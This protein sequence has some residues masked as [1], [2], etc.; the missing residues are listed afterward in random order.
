MPDKN[1]TALVLAAGKGT[2][3]HSAKAKVLQTILNE[4]MLFY[5]YEAL[6]PIMKEN[7]L[8]VVGHGVDEVKKE[9]PDMANRFVM[10]KEQLGT[11]HALQEA[12]AE[13]EKTNSTHCLVIN[14]DTPLVTVEALDRLV[15]AQGC[16]DLAFM[17]ITPRDTAAFGRVVRDPE[18]R[19]KAIVEAKDYDFSVH[20]PVTGEVNAGI[21]LLKIE[22]IGP[23]LG[24]LENENNSGEYYITDLVELAVNQGLSVDGVQAGNDI[25]LMGINSP[26]ELLTAENTLK[27][28]IVDE[29]I[30][31]GV[32]IHNPDTVTIGPKVTV[33][34]GA[35]IFG[36]CEI[37]G[38]SFVAAGARMGSYNFIKDSTFAAG[39]VVREFNHIEGAQVGEG[40]S[41]GPYSRLRPDAVLAKNSRIGNFV[42]MK[43][44]TLGEGAKASHLTYL[45][46]A[47]V[48]AGA[49]IGAGTIT[50]NYDGRNKFVTKIGEGAFI[51]SNTALVAPVSVGKHALIGAGSTI[52]K[53]VPD[54]QTGIARG[55]QTNLKRTLKK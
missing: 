14:G 21:Y 38:K 54:N 41:V 51:G 1:I 15:A 43:K 48:G 23:L 53:D 20:G 39:C 17:T 18:R 31:A 6:K 32:I 26:R 50:C 33:E 2:R 49:N 10:Q 36:H 35:E 47:E 9:F 11:G 3:M 25:S 5:V 7:I 34:P 30:D 24:R 46:D 40:V 22:T 4:P 44:A 55:K 27:R 8:T 28:Q 45:G 16:C 13:V 19:I 37:Y 12:W 52:T 42:E 29:L